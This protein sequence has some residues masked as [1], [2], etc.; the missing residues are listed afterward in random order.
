[1]DA[2]E[3]TH[4]QG[5]DLIQQY[6]GKMSHCIVLFIKPGVRWMMG[7]ANESWSATT[8]WGRLLKMPPAR[9]WH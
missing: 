3:L 9:G 5:A 1:M 8:F 2:R 4:Q 6:G 7:R